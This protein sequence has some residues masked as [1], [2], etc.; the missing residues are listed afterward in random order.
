MV[1][2]KAKKTNTQDR[3]KDGYMVRLPGQYGRFFKALA[4]T[5]KRPVTSQILIYL[6][7]SI[8]RHGQSLPKDEK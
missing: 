7:E 3:H 2:R 8:E 6:D 4:K 5:N 1:K